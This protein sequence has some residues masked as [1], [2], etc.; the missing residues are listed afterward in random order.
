MKFEILFVL[1]LC[2]CLILV[3]SFNAADKLAWKLYKNQHKKQYRANHEDILRMNKFMQN[4]NY[5]NKHNKLHK[6]G[7]ET[8]ELGINK[9]TDLMDT[10]RLHLTGFVM[11]PNNS[12]VEFFESEVVFTATAAPASLNWVEKG[13]VTGVK[14]QG[15]CGSCYA[16]SSLGSLEGQ[17]KKKTGKLIELSE[18]NVVDCSKK[19]GNNGCNGGNMGLCYNYI[20]DNGGIALSKD[21]RYE[22]KD[23]GSCRYKASMS[24]GSKVQGYKQVSTNEN[25]LKQ[26]L[27]TVGPISVGLNASPKSFNFYKS[28]V[29]NDRSCTKSVLNHGVVLVGYGTDRVAG[30]YWIIKNSWST[31]WGE[32]GYMRIARNREMCGINQ[33][34]TYPVL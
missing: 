9:Y 6:A 5:I 17:I 25:I 12:R 16:F 20:R 32:N 31:S 18:Q 33:Y 14:D 24:S 27:A 7:N 13:Y 11:E 8:Y 22:G 26:T 30:D 19:Y 21:Y 1:S 10:E 4:V 28:G 29:Y 15:I 34:A 23:T 2:C 3:E